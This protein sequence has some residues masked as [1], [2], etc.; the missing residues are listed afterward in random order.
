MLNLVI[1]PA[2][3]ARSRSTDWLGFMATAAWGNDALDR[4][5]DEGSAKIARMGAAIKGVQHYALPFLQALN[6]ESAF[7][8]G[9][10]HLRVVT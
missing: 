7:P 3:E 8:K 10:K 1:P 6:D 4:D 2:Q 9:S 5:G